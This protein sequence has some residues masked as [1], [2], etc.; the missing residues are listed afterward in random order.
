MSAPTRDEAIAAAAATY[1]AWVDEHPDVEAE[2][3]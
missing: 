3:S 2:A 1:A